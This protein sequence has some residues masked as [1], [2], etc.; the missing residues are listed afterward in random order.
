MR[1]ELRIEVA[2]HIIGLNIEETFQAPF[3]KNYAVFLSAGLPEIS[4]DVELSPDVPLLDGSEP[5][6]EF[7]DKLIT[8]ISEYLIGSLDLQ[9][10]SGKIKINPA[11]FLHSLGT[12]LRN[13]FT[14]LAV[15]ED[16]GIVLHAVGI[17]RDEEVYIF[18]GP[19]GAGKTTVAKLSEGKVILSDDLVLMK[20]IDNEFMVFPTP[21]WGDKQ[22]G[23]RENKPYRINSMFRLIKDKMVYLEEFSPAHALADIF[24]IPHMEPELIPKDALLARFFEL[25]SAVPYYRLHF[26]PEP[27]FW[28]CIE[29]ERMKNGVKRK[30]TGQVRQDCLKVNR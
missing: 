4:L 7:H 12:F 2:N 25:I 28:D 22:I 30:N 23:P 26:L 1:R 13:I 14:L 5:R 10:K 20:K 17:V 19:S 15:L 27:S 3:I 21:D 29:E 11:Y 24:T 8:V 18:I 6:L 9:T 16:N